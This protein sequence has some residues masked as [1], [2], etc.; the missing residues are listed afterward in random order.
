MSTGSTDEHC[1]FASG[2]GPS[3]FM[4]LPPGVCTDVAQHVT[5]P[6]EESEIGSKGW[7][8][9]IEEK[10]KTEKMTVNKKCFTVVIE[11][12]INF[13]GKTKRYSSNTT[14]SV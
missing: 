7:N 8:R 10:K 5:T 2:R 3:S 12:V 14:C 1:V 6:P 11:E 9:G 13:N 4:V